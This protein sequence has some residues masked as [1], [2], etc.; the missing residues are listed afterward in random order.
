[1]ACT[2]SPTPSCGTWT[3]PAAHLASCKSPGACSLPAG[4]VERYEVTYFD[5]PRARTDASGA[6][7][8]FDY[9][10][11]LRLSSVRA[12]DGSTWTYTYDAV[13]RLIGECDFN[14]RAQHYVLD[15]A[16]QLASRFDAAGGRLDFERDPIGRLI[17]ETD[18]S[19]GQ[20][21]MFTYDVS[22]RLTAASNPDAELAFEHDARGRVTAEIVNGRRVDTRYDAAGRRVRRENPSGHIST[23]DYDACGRVRELVGSGHAVRFG[24]DALGRETS[25]KFGDGVVLAQE[26][27]T[28]GR[29]SAQ[30]LRRDAPMDPVTAAL[31]PEAGARELHRRTFTY[32][33]DGIPVVVDDSE[34]G[35]ATFALDPVGRVTGVDGRSWRE[36]YAYDALGNLTHAEATGDGAELDESLSGAR[37][38]RGTLPRRAGRTVYEHD[39]QGRLVRRSSKTLS[40]KTRTWTFTW[41][42]SDRLTSA[43]DD[44]GRVWTYQ[45]DPLGR[46]IAKQCHTP[47][48]EALDRIDFVWDGVHLIEQITADGRALSWDHRPGTWDVVG[49]TRTARIDADGEQGRIDR[50][51]HAIVS[52]LTGAPTR[53]LDSDGAS[54]WRRGPGLWGGGQSGP[55]LGFPGQYRDAETGLFDNL[56]RPYD[57]ASAPTSHPTRSDC[58]P[59]PITTPTSPTPWC[60]STLS[61]WPRQTTHSATRATRT[62][63]VNRRWTLPTTWRACGPEQRPTRNGR[64]WETSPRRTR[65]ATSTRPSPNTG[66]RSSNSKRRTAHG[67]SSSTPTTRPARTSTRVSPKMTLPG[68]GSTSDGTTRK[69]HLM[70]HIQTVLPTRH[71]LRG[72]ARSTNRGAAT[73]TSSMTRG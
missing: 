51:F 69:R 27:D 47:D 70:A 44:R 38:F 6:R 22:G 28:A 2:L 54:V 66:E 18:V 42:A 30:I 10:T 72:M 46:R 61:G 71:P 17:R 67:S 26:W 68:R 58:G 37:Q 55:P 31:S 64:S 19:T 53:M 33:E 35:R 24:Y 20:S 1:M 11:E 62:P 29:L 65:P 73:T 9:D 34:L 15:A 5:K 57:P 48:G 43:V 56:H 45:Y 14:G 63:P 39:A 4:G 40:G 52:D 3:R 25:R 50:E 21:T 7:Y 59:P 16:G 23:W 60:G 36:R 13:G 41:S 8:T 49:Q 32:R 12:P